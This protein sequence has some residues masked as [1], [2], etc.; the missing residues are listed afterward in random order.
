MVGKH[1]HY[2]HVQSL[3]ILPQNVMQMR[4]DT[5]FQKKKS[6]VRN[7]IL[8]NKSEQ[9][10]KFPIRV[11]IKLN[12]IHALLI[13]SKIFDDAYHEREI[14]YYKLVEK[15]KKI[16]AYFNIK[17]KQNKGKKIKEQI[18]KPIFFNQIKKFLISFRQKIYEHN[19]HDVV[20]FIRNAKFEDILV[21]IL[22]SFVIPL[23][24]LNK[25]NK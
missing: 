24:S 22:C 17:E 21:I 9:K 1:L 15:F 5:K 10:K 6:N 2:L 20:Y 7:N 16:E 3:F 13:S 18:Q 11:Q 19:E 23:K 8:E 25:Q 14:M 12:H 4:K